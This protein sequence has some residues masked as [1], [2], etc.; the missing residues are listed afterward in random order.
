[1]LLDV[2]GA[3]RLLDSYFTHF[4]RSNF[5]LVLS[6]PTTLSY[7]SPEQLSSLRKGHYSKPQENR[8]K[9]QVFSL[10]MTMMEAMLLENSFECYEMNLLK[11]LENKVQ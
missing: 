10:G 1:M 7:L 5:E 11:L 4:G 9:N 6:S 2:E 8:V 3:P